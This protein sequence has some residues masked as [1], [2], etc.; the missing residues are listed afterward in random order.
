LLLGSFRRSDA[1]SPEIFSAA[2]KDVLARYDM[3]IQKEVIRPGKWKFLPTAYELR[4]VCEAIANERARA[5][6]RDESI[7]QQ[8]AERDERERELL[9]KPSQTEAEFK[10]EMAARGLPIERREQHIEASVLR[11]KYGVSEAQWNAIEDLPASHEDRAAEDRLAGR[12]PYGDAARAA[13]DLAT[14]KLLSDERKAP[15]SNNPGFRP[16][17]WIEREYAAAGVPPV[18][19]GALFVRRRW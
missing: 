17:Y 13:A 9:A 1:D 3:D 10:A 6:Q 5:K 15:D 19:A 11:A 12:M 18:M 7:R 16:S 2:L 14:R 8:L 4:E